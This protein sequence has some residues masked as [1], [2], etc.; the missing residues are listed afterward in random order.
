[1]V[2]T[3]TASFGQLSNGLIKRSLLHQG[4]LIEKDRTIYPFL[5]LLQK[6]GVKES[7]VK[8][9]IPH[10]KEKIYERGE[11]ILSKGD[12]DSKLSFL[13]SGLVRYYSNTDKRQVTFD[14]TLPNSIM[15]HYDSYFNQLPTGFY[16]E[17]IIK[18][19]VFYINCK[20][21][22]N[23]A[24]SFPYLNLLSRKS[25][26]VILAKKLNRELNLL[27]YSPEERYELLIKDEPKL[28]EHIPQKYLASYLGIVPETL[29]RIRRRII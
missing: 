8:L 17:A 1:M 15:C 7:D 12:V 28:F 22:Q 6:L 16:S 29:S 10:I 14:F 13:H 11:S 4:S 3:S 21:L 24:I 5:L 26:E 25:L 27:S 9:F 23:L 2:F 20:D 19:R 18:S